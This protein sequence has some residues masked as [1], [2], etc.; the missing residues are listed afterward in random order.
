[1]KDP[2]LRLFLSMLPES[3]ILA[4]ARCGPVGLW[5]KAPGTNGSIVG[6]LLYVALIHNLPL[7]AQIIAMALLILVSIGVCDEAERRM[8]KRDPGEII[9]DEIVAQP[10]VFIGL[11]A[12]II[13]TGWALGA[14]VLG[15]GLFRLF[16]IWKPFFINRLQ[17]LPGGTGVVADDL[18]AAAVAWVVLQGILHGVIRAGWVG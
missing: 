17:F 7:P 12:T 1:M 3:L 16:D 5:G 13:G 4:L 15:F 18:A 11:P 2:R 14:L 6:V 10:L 8:S 9:I